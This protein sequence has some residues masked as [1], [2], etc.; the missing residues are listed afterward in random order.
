[1]QFTVPYPWWVLLLIAAA[2]VAVAWAVYVRAVLPRGRRAALVTLRALALL[3][4]VAC[5]L[6]PVRVMPPA[7]SEAVVAVLV[8][9]SR[10][11]RLPDA[12]GRPRIETATA[13][14]QHEV[15]RSLGTRFRPELWQFG[16]GLERVQD[17]LVGAAASGS[18]LS[19]AL[20]LL[21]ERYR[22]Q[23]PRA[24]V[25]ISDGGD[26]GADDAAAVAAEAGI[27]VYAIGVGTSR[28]AFDLEVLDVSAGENVLADSTVDI[29]AALVSRGA[30]APFDVRLLEN[31]RPVDLRRAVPAAGGSPVRIVFTASPARDAATVYT[32]EI[33]SEAGELTVDNNR[34]SLVVEPPARRRRILV[35][36]GAPGFEHS[37]FKRALA[38]D[39]AF[40]VDSVV[41]K[42]RNERGEPT[43]FVQAREARAARLTSGFPQEPAALFAYDAVVLANVAGDALSRAQLQMLARFVE[44]RG[45]GLLLLGAKTYAQQGFV[46]T[47]LEELLPM[48][49]VGLGSGVMRASEASPSGRVDVTDDGRPHPVM[50]IAPIEEVD[51][52]WRA[53]PPLAGVA[54]LGPLRPGAQ[55]L[56]VV[57]AADGPR[58]LVALQRYGQ[59][60]VLVFTGEASWRWRM[61]LPSGDRTYERFWRQAVRWISSGAPDQV[62]V[63]APD[64]AAGAASVL[65]IDVRD[66]EFAPVA[67]ADVGVRITR[68]GERADDIPAAPSNPSRGRYAAGVRFDEPGVYKV[69]ATA[70]RDGRTVGTADRFVLVGGVDREMADP[71]LNEEVLRRVALASGG[72]YLHAEEAHR[73]APLLSSTAAP[74]APTLVPLWHNAWVFAALALLLAME[75]AVRRRWGLR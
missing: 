2:T 27:P 63:A 45:G 40:E 1:M 37:F 60:R 51:A 33:P 70:R 34:R 42:G 49:M 75:W 44:R 24:V 72:E 9:G 73:L 57:G 25:V 69:S 35:V 53:M 66:E 17:D 30:A 26:T 59:G 14:W 22:E 71:R 21:R 3:L 28:P 58:P 55:A 41:R 36:E 5:L 48:R 62:A 10:S 12:S 31:G 15:R 7:A 67:D 64:V 52:R 39:A 11:M 56:A 43:Y 54:A 6:G 68:P 50:R 19:R 74:A 20:R 13:L 65:S 8:D 23:P 18:D 61:Q 47:P 32:A 38:E 16:A 46:G 29:T 4:L